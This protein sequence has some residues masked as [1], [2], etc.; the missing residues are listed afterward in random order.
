MKHILGQIAY[1]IIVL[2]EL[3]AFAL[4]YWI[5]KDTVMSILSL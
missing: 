2:L 3:G 5:S 4:A 1:A